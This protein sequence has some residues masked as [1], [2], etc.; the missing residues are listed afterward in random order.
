MNIKLLSVVV[1]LFVHKFL[2]AQSLSLTAAQVAG[3]CS[4]NAQI[5][6]TVTGG[7]AP[8]IF[9]LTA[10]AAGVTYPTA[11]QNS[12]NFSGLKPGAYTVQVQ[13]NI[14]AVF[15]RNVT[16]TST[17]VS[18]NLSNAT[19]TPNKCPL[20]P[21]GTVTATVSAGRT[22]YSYRLLQGVAEIKPAQASNTFTSV[23]DGSYTAEVTDACGEIRTYAVTVALNDYKWADIKSGDNGF[24]NSGYGGGFPAAPFDTT[25]QSNIYDGPLLF[26]CDSIAFR[27]FNTLTYN[28]NDLPARNA[29]RRV[30][31]KQLSTNNI[32]WDYTY[33]PSDWPGGYT[34]PSVH[35]K[36]NTDY[37]FY[38]N[39]LC[40]DID[41]ADRNY[42]YANTD[43]YVPSSGALKTCGG[44]QLSG[45]VPSN[46]NTKNRYNNPYDTITIISSTLAGDT[47]VGKR[48]LLNYADRALNQGL[49]ISGITPGNT[50]TLRVNNSCTTYTKSVYVNMP[51]ALNANI[52]SA[53]GACKV[54]TALLQINIGGYPNVNGKMTYRINSGPASFTDIN[55]NTFPISYP[56]TDS[57]GYGNRISI[58]NFP[59]GTYSIDFWDQCGNTVPTMNYTVTDAEVLKLSG[60][61]SG[62]QQ[63]AGAS[64]ITYN[65]ISSQRFVGAVSLLKKNAAGNYVAVT[66]SPQYNSS[67]MPASVV[68][69]SLA[70]GDYRVIVLTSNAVLLAAPV[71]PATCDTLFKQDITLAYQLPIIDTADGFVCTPGANDGKITLYGTRGVRPYQ[72]Q[73]VDGAGNPLTPY[74]TDSVFTGLTRGLHNFRI[75]DN[76]GNATLFAYQVDTLKNLTITPNTSCYNPG[77]PL[78]LTADSIYQ[79]S[80]SWSYK[81]TPASAASVIANTRTLYFSSLNSSHWGIYTLSYTKPGCATLKSTDAVVVSCII[82]PVQL[83]SFNAYADNK[84]ETNIQWKCDLTEYIR[85]FEIQKSYDGVT[86][87]LA[88][89]IGNKG[90]GISS[91]SFHDNQP[92]FGKTFYRLRITDM[93][94]ENI[95][96]NSKEIKTNC[97]IRSAQVYPNPVNDKLTVAVT[98]F[99]SNITVNIYST[100]GQLLLSKKIIAGINTLNTAVLPEGQYNLVVNDD[101]GRVSSQK[102][103]VKR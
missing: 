16:V 12:T 66:S 71:P 92:L 56:I 44:Y 93:N 38:F 59:K 2:P 67:T 57:I 60:S 83:L 33:R 19:S 21:S 3:N 63:C 95:F 61:I 28:G 81:S 75:K 27:I 32:I 46:W 48:T 97:K 51:T 78:T 43:Y 31:I 99:S 98:G 45:S 77:D 5:N 24:V 37:R 30:Y 73:R 69:P 8:Y 91:Y 52:T 82:L 96:S 47:M 26:T 88:G 41:S 58:R 84:C 65:N 101:E 17:Y 50:Y 72:F 68:F 74:Q 40:N 29:W 62:T 76:C 1:C 34:S 15:S 79:A 39:D 87:E 18:L 85:S 54:N 90:R 102:I 100:A 25:K 89:T 23:T 13:D 6:A 4:S 36:I 94:G 22:P 11:W 7:T 49:V 80:Y 70:D 35:L 10:G 103:L 14:G 9:R 53:S 55:G 20:S 86:W 64:S 42:N